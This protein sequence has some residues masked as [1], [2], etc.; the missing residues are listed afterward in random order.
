MKILE[1]YKELSLSE[2]ERKANTNDKTILTHIGE[3]EWCG[4]IKINRHQKSDANGR[5]FTTVKKI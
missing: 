3:L 1:E 5:P 2:I 4:K